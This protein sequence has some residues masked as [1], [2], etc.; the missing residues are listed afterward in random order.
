MREV[1]TA[2]RA[3]SDSGPKESTVALVLVAVLASSPPSPASGLLSRPAEGAGVVVVPASSGA[4]PTSLSLQAR[5][6][7][8]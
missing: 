8:M 1:K 3:E 6:N 4:K 7:K 2:I 5:Q